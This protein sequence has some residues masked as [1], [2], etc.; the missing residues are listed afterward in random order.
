MQRPR[1]LETLTLL[2]AVLAGVSYVLSWNLALPLPAAT[3]WKGAGV[4]LLALYAAQRARGLDGWLL[5]AVMAFGALGD[6][7]IE[8][9]GLIAGAV[10]FLAGHLIAIALYLR[11]R[12]PRPSLGQRLLA[13]V[14]VPATVA[15]AWL[16]PAD[17]A[18]AP[19]I[20]L[21]ALG[22]SLMAATAWL[23][24]FPRFR[25][26]L[27]AVMFVASDLLIFARGG[28]LAHAAWIGLAIW[29]LYFAGQVLICVGVGGLGAGGSTPA[30][31]IRVPQPR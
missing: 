29:G 28:P 18:M 10:A 8:V 6:M 3:A 19:G 1:P 31:S 14:L 25:V 30:S 7:L 24:R 27:G 15:T 11:N 20:A 13:L 4:A 2:A 17:R 9:A 12:R 26:G 5:V 23:S 16:L 21:Y 22:L